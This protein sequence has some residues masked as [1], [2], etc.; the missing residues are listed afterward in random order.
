MTPKE[1]AVWRFEQ[2]PRI[3]S[4]EELITIILGGKSFATAREVAEEYGA[5]SC[6]D[7]K[8][9][10][11]LGTAEYHDLMKIKGMTKQRALRL[12]AAIELG[13]RL[14]EQKAGNPVSFSNP[15]KVWLYFSPKLRWKTQ[16][17]F[18]VAYVNVKNRL[19]GY[20][21]ITKGNLNAAPVDIKETLRW[22]IRYKAYGLIL[23]H[24][25]PSGVPE[26]SDEDKE[27]TKAFAKAAELLDMEVLDHVIIGDGEYTS[28]HAQGMI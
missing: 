16:E 27:L 25:H 2:A 23:V 24:N 20:R 14:A 7:F 3:V 28:F 26:P 13:N 19:L 10:A 5:H 15:E 8:K 18:V 17:H 22:G 9:G 4:T 1:E 6:R 11:M 12:C 21:V